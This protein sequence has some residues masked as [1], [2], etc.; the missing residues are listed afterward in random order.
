M[1]TSVPA[2]SLYHDSLRPSSN[3]EET[4]KEGGETGRETETGGITG[5]TERGRG[6]GPL[7]GSNTESENAVEKEVC[8]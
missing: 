2:A 4:T 5:D 1:N 7:R 6:R 8:I 3:R